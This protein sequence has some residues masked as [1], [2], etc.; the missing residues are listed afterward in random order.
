MFCEWGGWYG[1]RRNRAGDE[2]IH[3][4]A[5]GRRKRRLLSR[6]HLLG[7]AALAAAAAGTVASVALVVGS[8]PLRVAPSQPL[9]TTLIERALTA[10]AAV[11]VTIVAYAAL[12]RSL[13][14]QQP[15]AQRRADD[16]PALPAAMAAVVGV[17][18]RRP[19]EWVGAIPLVVSGLRRA[20]AVAPP[21]RVTTSAVEIEAGPLLCLS[22]LGPLRLFD[23]QG[24]VP[25]LRAA[26]RA[27]LV[28]LALHPHGCDRETLL[29]TLWP[30]MERQ[31]S[32]QRLWQTTSECR[33]HLGA[34]ISRKH[35]H[36]QLDREHVR[37]DLD[38][39][40]RLRDEA[41]RSPAPAGRNL[42]I[43]A[44]ELIRGVPL[45]DCDYPWIDPHRRRLH[46]LAADLIITLAR[47]HLANGEA[48]LAISLAE[49][50]LELDHLDEQ[51]WRIALQAEAQLGLRQALT[52]RYRHLEQ[53][54]D[55]QLGLRPD[56]QTRQLYRTLLSQE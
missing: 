33:R 1:Y 10:A 55:A 44:Y 54:L 28:Y 2:A 47:T 23:A 17:G 38:Q 39:L 13:P 21:G 19:A 26:S 49:R 9:T 4:R 22:L 32:Q 30:E 48:T 36:Y 53:T 43:E 46:A 42:L 15:G 14:R 7:L 11:A 20:A 34:I 45:A 31:R 27:L 52:R 8:W 40:E 56:Q 25:P 35:D 16:R 51:L 6:R 24:Q 3:T 50:G 12:G 37:I 29:E 41:A 5:P 18:Q